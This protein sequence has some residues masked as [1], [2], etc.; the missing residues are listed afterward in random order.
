MKYRQG[1]G[2]KKVHSKSIMQNTVT[3]RMSLPKNDSFQTNVRA[4]KRE[5]TLVG[6]RASERT[7]GR[8]VGIS[9][10][11]LVR[12]DVSHRSRTR[13]P[14]TFIERRRF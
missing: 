2:E 7:K 6:K 3:E 10:A 8:L 11:D 1:W 13:W 5:V 9:A 4:S 12:I 14:F